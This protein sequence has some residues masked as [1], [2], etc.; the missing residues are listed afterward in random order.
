MLLKRSSAPAASVPLYLSGC[1]TCG[2]DPAAVRGQRGIVRG[3][4]GGVV[5]TSA[6]FMYAFLISACDARTP[7][8]SVCAPRAPRV[9]ARAP[10]P[11]LPPVLSG[12]VSSVSGRVSSLFGPRRPCGPTSQGAGEGGG[13]S[14]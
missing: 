14:D 4:A 3:D 6:S 9:S 5:R 8:P 11:P 7:T 1:H 2:A 10:P 13:M 12:R